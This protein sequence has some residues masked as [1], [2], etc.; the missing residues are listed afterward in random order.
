M[1]YYSAVKE[2]ATGYYNYMEEYKKYAES[3]KPD[4]K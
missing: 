1:N 2:Q 4:F 3:K